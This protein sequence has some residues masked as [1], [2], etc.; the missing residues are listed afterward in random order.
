M[1]GVEDFHYFRARS[2]AR[3][4]KAKKR[5]ADVALSLLPSFPRRYATMA[6]PSQAGTQAS[7]SA[8]DSAVF[9]AQAAIAFRR[10]AGHGPQF[11]PASDA[12]PLRLVC[13]PCIADV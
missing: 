10:K 13:V 6:K 12:V 4:R 9:S 5:R 1:A 3:I 2:T 7:F 11:E 8:K